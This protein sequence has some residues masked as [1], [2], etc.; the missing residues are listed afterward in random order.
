MY[1]CP[2]SARLTLQQTAS[3]EPEMVL[4]K[5]AAP[6]KGPFVSCL[7]AQPTTATAA[8]TRATRRGNAIVLVLRM[9]SSTQVLCLFLTGHHGLEVPR[10]ASPENGALISALQITV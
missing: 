6:L 2:S 3:P 9:T 10:L 5:G 7:D 8:V 1:P 4:L